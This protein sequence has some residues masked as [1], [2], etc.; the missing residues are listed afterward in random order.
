[1]TTAISGST[2]AAMP[3]TP[4]PASLT[5]GPGGAM[6]KDQFLQLLVA[7][8]KNQDP[9][10]PMDGTQM[11]AQLAQF[12]SVEQ[13]TEINQTLQAQSTSQSGL[14]SLLAENGALGAVGKTVLADASAVDTSRGAPTTVFADVPAGT[15]SATLHVYDAQGTEVATQDLGAP[16]SGRQS[17]ALSGATTA[18]TGGTFK[19]VVETTGSSG[20]ATSAPTYVTGRVDG[21][22]FS[23]AGPVVTIG[24]VAVPY[25]AITEITN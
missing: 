5:Q 24:N 20:Q 12:S 9:L 21:V 4:Q 11:A 8:M 6:G 3:S 1:M 14:S 19:Y 7:Q 16:A 23:S 17:F 15:R 25:M 10:N 18:L 22:R 13:L 2:S